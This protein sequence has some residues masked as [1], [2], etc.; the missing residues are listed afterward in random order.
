ME[1]TPEITREMIEQARFPKKNKKKIPLN[2]Y[3]KFVKENFAKIR[4][5]D[6]VQSSTT[7]MSICAQ[8]WKNIHYK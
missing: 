6:D 2:S 5:S 8:K 3:Q 1:I 4:K 7:A